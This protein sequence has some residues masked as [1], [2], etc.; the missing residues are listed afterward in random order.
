M[1]RDSRS[2]KARF[3]AV[4]IASVSLLLIAFAQTAWAADV[5]APAP[6]PL[7][8]PLTGPLAGPFAMVQP[9]ALAGAAVV[10]AIALIVVATYVRRGVLGQAVARTGAGAPPQPKRRLD[11]R[12]HRRP[13]QRHAA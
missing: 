6:G 2:A 4:L 8:A 11:R 5:P 9:A 13:T 12:H 1:K 3:I 7:V 10:V